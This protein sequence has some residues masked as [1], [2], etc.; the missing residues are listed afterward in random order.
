MERREFEVLVLQALKSLPP[1]FRKRLENIEVLV[2]NQPDAKLLHRL[3]KGRGKILG[4]YEG[5]PLKFRGVWYANVLPDRI[6]LFQKE[7][8]SLCTTPDEVRELVQ[9]TLFH[10]IGHYFGLK[11]DELQNL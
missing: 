3:G 4:L 2:E 10:E 9:K 8:E 1:L 5:I 11:E 7:I 6:T